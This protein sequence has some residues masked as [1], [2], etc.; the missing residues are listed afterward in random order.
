MRTL[1]DFAVG[2][3]FDLGETTV[4]EEEIIRF[5]REFDPQPFHVDPVAAKESAFGGLVASG[6]HVASI[7]MRRFVDSLLRDA[8]S[9]GGLGVDDMH[10][11]VPVRPGDTLRASAEVLELRPSRS[12][13]GQ[14]VLGMRMQ[15]VNQRGE[16]TWYCTAYSL[17]RH[18][19]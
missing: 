10:W 11:K 12:K 7:F 8:E 16:L 4:T 17:L 19:V 3:V 9:L 13:P 18:G 5:G 14:G 6:W 2:D 1:E 15:L